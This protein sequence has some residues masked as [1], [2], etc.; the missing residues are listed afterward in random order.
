[1]RT[2]IAIMLL[3]AGG[4][5]LG[6]LTQPPIVEARDTRRADQ[7]VRAAKVEAAHARADRAAVERR[8]VELWRRVDGALA[9]YER[10]TNVIERDA[11]RRR[12][13]QLRW[14]MDTVAVRLHVE[15]APVR[16]TDSFRR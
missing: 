7:A 6:R 8:F 13:D 3:V 1:M 4:W 9:D 10:A 2:S 14:D 11:V 12:L 5:F 16:V 15:R